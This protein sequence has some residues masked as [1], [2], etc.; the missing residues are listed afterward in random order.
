[1]EL[2]PDSICMMPNEIKF[3]DFKIVENPC[4]LS[5]RLWERHTVGTSRIQN[6]QSF[7]AIMGNF[8]KIKYAKKKIL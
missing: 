8:L 3:P 1:M 5:T 2:Q 7:L 4:S 6:K